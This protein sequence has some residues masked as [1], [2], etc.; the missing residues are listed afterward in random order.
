MVSR[1]FVGFVPL[2]RSLMLTPMWPGIHFSTDSRIA[3]SAP[4][5]RGSCD[6]AADVFRD[7][8]HIHVVVRLVENG[9]K[10]VSENGK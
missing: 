9:N 1:F 10:T 6:N 4:L 2:F 3:S 7:L 5:T 8:V